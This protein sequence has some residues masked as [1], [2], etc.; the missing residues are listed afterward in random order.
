MWI[1]GIGISGSTLGY[2]AKAR[3]QTSVWEESCWDSL[4]VQI[5]G[6]RFYVSGC[7]RIAGLEEGV[8][9]G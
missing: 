8:L 5:S 1:P 4:P 7:L 2:S 6:D 9:V 3:L